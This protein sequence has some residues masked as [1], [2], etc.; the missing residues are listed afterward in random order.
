[1]FAPGLNPGE[2]TYNGSGEDLIPVGTNHLFLF[3]I[4]N[5]NSELLTSTGCSSPSESDG[6]FHVSSPSAMAKGSTAGGR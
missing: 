1:M 3:T 6:S 5:V 2:N 4:T